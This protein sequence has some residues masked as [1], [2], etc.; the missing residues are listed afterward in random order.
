T[1][2][3][4]SVLG[5]V[6]AC[7]MIEPPRQGDLD[8]QKPPGAGGPERAGLRAAIVPLLPLVAPAAVLNSVGSAATFWV[9][10]S[11]TIAPAQMTRFIAMVT[12]AEAAGAFTAARL[13]GGVRTQLGLAAAGVALTVLAF[14]SGAAF[15]PAVVTVSLL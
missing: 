6:I 7:A 2:T 4:L 15:Q 11:V 10:A 8:T 13:R 3:S 5:L 14:V 1:E 12:L 9:Q